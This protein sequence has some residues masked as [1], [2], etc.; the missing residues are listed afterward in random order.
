[1]SNAVNFHKLSL[2]IQ[3]DCIVMITEASARAA[4]DAIAFAEPEANELKLMRLNSMAQAI[5]IGDTILAAAL[6]RRSPFASEFP[7]DRHW[8]TDV[9]TLPSSK[10]SLPMQRK[11]LILTWKD[12]IF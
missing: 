9:R 3:K 1:M 11:G 2:E 7:H 10:R 4:R 6:I 12:M 5:S 8:Q